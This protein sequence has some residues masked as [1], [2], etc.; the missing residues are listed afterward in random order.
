MSGPGRIDLLLGSDIGAWITGFVDPADVGT[1]ITRDPAIAA[2]AAARGMPTATDP[3]AIRPAPAA[4]SAHWP[5]V[6]AAADLAAWEMA[7]NLHP[8]LL[9]WGR[10]YAPVFWALWAGEPAGAT[11]HVLS[12][13]LDKGAIVDQA[14][15]AVHAGDTGASLYA[16]VLD[17]RRELVRAWWPRLV[18]GE[19]PTGVAQ[20]AG[21]SYHSRADFLALRDGAGLDA[22]AVSAHDIVRLC[23]AL[24]MPGMPGPRVDGVRLAIVPDPPPADI[25]IVPAP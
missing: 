24:A 8:G 20:P 16:R 14:P 3:A 15:V 21:G 6:L 13:G 10:G 18:A 19:R 1:V 17:A 2:A 11:L 23:R 9:P 12:E 25:P 5:A 7:W 22:D 4:F